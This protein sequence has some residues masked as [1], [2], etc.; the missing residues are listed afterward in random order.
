[1][2]D[3]AIGRLPSR[4][5]RKHTVPLSRKSKKKQ[6]RGGEPRS[7]DGGDAAE[8]LK[9]AISYLQAEQWAATIETLEKALACNPRVSE[10]HFYLA[11]AH[12]MIG[13]GEA[14]GRHFEA[15]RSVDPARAALLEDRFSWLGTGSDVKPLG[16]SQ[17]GANTYESHACSDLEAAQRFLLSREV[18]RP[19]HYVDVETPDG[20]WGIDINGIYQGHLPDWKTNIDLADC[21]G[22]ASEPTVGFAS[23]EQCVKGLSD[24]FVV[25]IGCGRC[26]HEWLGALRYQDVTIAHC[27]SCS[28]YNRVD[29]GAYHGVLIGEGGSVEPI[30][31]AVEGKIEVECVLE[32]AE[33]HS[34]GLSEAKIDEALATCARFALGEVLKACDPQ[35][36]I[37]IED[38]R[39]IR[40]E[41]GNSI[42]VGVSIPV[43]RE[44]EVSAAAAAAAKK[45][46]ADIDRWG[47]DALITAGRQTD[48]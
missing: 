2:G 3:K 40:S 8:L 43:E 42:V 46:L 48:S 25:R 6:R 35:G 18:D 4:G 9:Q 17:Q 22:Y 29:S 23:L 27:P 26:G 31:S 14:A 47:I 13:N 1:V 5:E 11:Q 41:T 20:L 45:L 34:A 10:P 19:Q 28:T 37:P 24:N 16:K 33:R 44:G 21:D 36:Q 7:P 30:G 12:A 38:C 39:F 32:I 15:F